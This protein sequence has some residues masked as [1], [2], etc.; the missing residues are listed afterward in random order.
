GRHLAVCDAVPT[1]FATG[2]PLATDDRVVVPPRC[3]CSATAGGSPSMSST[4][5][6]DIWLTKPRAYGD[7]DSRYLRCASAYNVPNASDDLPEPETPV[8]TTSA[9][10]GIST[11]TFLRLCSRAPRTRTNRSMPF[12]A[13]AQR[14]IEIDAT[15]AAGLPV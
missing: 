11:S 6:T 14:G 1:R 3:C 9:S 10:R 8:N 13:T 4:S 12:A 7:T 2:V 5:G 15:S